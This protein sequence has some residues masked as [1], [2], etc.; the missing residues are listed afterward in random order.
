[1]KQFKQIAIPLLI[2]ILAAVIGAVM[3]LGT[4]C[5]LLSHYN[6]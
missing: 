6:Y 2:I 4:Y 1:M 5:W 3:F